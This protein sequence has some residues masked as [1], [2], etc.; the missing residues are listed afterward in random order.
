M[1][2]MRRRTPTRR[3]T[4]PA[5]RCCRRQRARTPCCGCSRWAGGRVGALAPLRGPTLVITPRGGL[6]CGLQGAGDS[7]A[8][9]A[10]SSESAKLAAHN[11]AKG[12]GRP[13]FLRHKD[14]VRGRA[15]RVWA[16]L[17]PAGSPCAAAGATVGMHRRAAAAT[18]LQEVRLYTALCLCHILRLNAP[19]TPYTDDQLQVGVGA[20]LQLAGAPLLCG[21]QE[22]VTAV[23]AGHF[24][25]ADAHVWGAGG[26]RLAPLPALPLH[27]GDRQPGGCKQRRGLRAAGVAVWATGKNVQACCCSRGR[28][29]LSSPQPALPRTCLS[30]RA[31]LPACLPT[32]ALRQVKCSLL[33]LDLPNAEELVCNLFAT[34]LD[35]VK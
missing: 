12:L 6:P 16:R 15:G 27:P 2:S 5:R 19:D 30:W 13:E 11:L 7:L 32:C 24:R 25:A 9:A 20:A 26:S 22:V 4:R 23:T 35:A 3:L 10:Q 33:I 31:Y 28:G 8:E 29:A 18:R 34:L 1:S 17:W 14:K 21:L